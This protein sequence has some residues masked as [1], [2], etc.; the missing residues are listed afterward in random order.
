VI[1]RPLHL[2]GAYRIEPQL[3]ADDRGAFARRFCADTFRAH[4]LESDLVQ[5][6][7]SFNARA[8]TL[9]GMH[10]QTLHL[11]TKLV[12]CTRGAVFD[13]M[14]DLRDGSATYGQ[15]HGDELSADNRMMLYIPKGFAHGFQTLVDDTEI[16][17][18]ITPAYVPGADSGFRFDDPSLA[19]NW[20]IADVIMSERDKFLPATFAG[21]RLR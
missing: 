17:Y 12:R 15:W 1:F 13:V 20:P 7:I 5:R 11:E 2:A 10:Y 18:E 16:D 21:I 19:I 8:G 9:R 4:G 14:V 6:S 3:I